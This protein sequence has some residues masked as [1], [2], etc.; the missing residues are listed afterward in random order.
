[1]G[2]DGRRINCQAA[3]IPDDRGM[4]RERPVKGKKISRIIKGYTVERK[5]RVSGNMRVVDEA[6]FTIYNRCLLLLPILIT[7]GFTSIFPSQD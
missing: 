3:K 6:I 1:L 5:L 4:A 2:T 7:T